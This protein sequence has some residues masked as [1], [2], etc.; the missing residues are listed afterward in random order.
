M[1]LELVPKKGVFPKPPMTP[2]PL[3]ARQVLLLRKAEKESEA[4]MSATGILLRH[5]AYLGIY[6]RRI[7]NPLYLY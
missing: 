3:N 7:Y 6:I 2:E 1:A 5:A 4:R